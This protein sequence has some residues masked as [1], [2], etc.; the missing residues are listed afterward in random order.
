MPSSERTLLSVECRRWSACVLAGCVFALTTPF[1]APLRA[2]ILSPKRGFADVGANYNNL[3]ATGAGWYYTWGT[4]EGSPGNF[5]ATHY[6][7]FW[8][9]PSQNTI[10]IVKNR[11]PEWVLGFNEPE[12]PDQANMSV[13]QAIASWTTISNSFAGTSTKLASP[14]VSDTGDGQAW[15]ASFMQQAAANDLRVDAVAFHWYGVSNPN[16]PAGAASSF[17]SRVDSYHNQ[18]NK[19]VFITEFAIH[20][21]GGA[22]SDEAI[23]EANRQFLDIVIPALE[24][25]SHVVGYAWYHWFSDA[26]LYQGGPA[27]PTPMGYSYVGAVGSGQ[28]ANISGQNLGEHVAYLSGGELTMNGGSAGTLRY[29]NALAGASSV[30]GSIDWALTGPSW[31]RIQPDATLRKGGANRITFGGGAITNNGVLEVTEGTLELGSPVAGNGSVLVKGGTLALTSLSSLSAVPLVEVRGGGTLDVSALGRGHSI[32]DGNTLNNERSGLIVGHVTATPGANI[33]GGGT[34]AGNVTAQ[35]G[36]VVRVGKDAAGV[37]SRFSIDD[38]ESYDLGD[39]RSVASPPWTAHQNTSLADIENIGGNKA[40]TFGWANDFRG[41]SR[42]LPDSAVI[43]DGDTATLFLRINSETGDPDHSVG[44]GDQATTSSVDFSDFEAQLRIKEGTTA[45]TFA[46]DA[47]SG[48]TFSATLASGLPLNTWH[49]VWM[50]VDQMSDT[51]DIYLNTGNSDATAGDKLNA[52]PLAYRNGTTSELN[53]IL[54][55]AGPAP[56]D[57]GVRIDDLFIFNGFD[58][59][60]PLVDFDPG[61]VWTAETLTVDGNYTQTAGATLDIDLGGTG[62][63]DYDVLEV[64]APRCWMAACKSAWRTVS[65]RRT[66]I[67]FAS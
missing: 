21:W 7:M 50:V 42:T 57:N 46:L 29:I 66:A 45:G 28:V 62:V 20:D 43:G 44:L 60:N 3:Q 55:L 40:L 23:I 17:L 36:S 34:F 4:G 19:P 51:Y 6:P 65:R 52:T 32:L 2:E 12:R 54:G 30:S 13:G 35:P 64:G 1:I 14:A 8:N 38:F 61:L 47:R 18:F 48:G 24:S 49:N 25:R 22:Y 59:T 56:I 41:V 26:N 11:N 9:A 37:A 39:V 10:N 16:N 53:T 58:L 63:G 15:L 31:V 67:C 33:S 27:V 5:D